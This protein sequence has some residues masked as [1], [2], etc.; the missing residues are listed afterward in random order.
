MKNFNI[1]LSI[2]GQ[3]EEGEY[4][5]L[6]SF[7]FVDPIGL[8]DLIEDISLWVLMF[9]RSN[10]LIDTIHVD[11]ADERDDDEILSDNDDHAL[12]AT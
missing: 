3:Y 1:T 12:G 11:S 8:D 9:E 6:D 5:D 10:M 7:R 2:R 4:L